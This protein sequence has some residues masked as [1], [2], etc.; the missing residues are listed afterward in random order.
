MGHTA[1]AKCKSCGHDFEVDHGGGFFF[2]LLRCDSCSRT[3]SLN[4]DEI[5]E[6][7][8][9]YLKGSG[10]PYSI[11][12]EEEWEY[13]RKNY[14]GDSISEEEYYKAVENIAGKCKCG[15]TFTFN[16]KPRCPEC[17]SLEIGEG[18]TLMCYD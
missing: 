12:G 1:S 8:L 11:V 14:K 6:P 10:M 17:N 18:E 13:A 16:A 3:K 7:H 15:G 9:Q 2:H 5:G 4:F